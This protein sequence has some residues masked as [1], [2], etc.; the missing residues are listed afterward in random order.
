MEAGPADHSALENSA[1]LRLRF[2][3]QATM[4]GLFSPW[5]VESIHSGS[6]VCEA[7]TSLIEPTPQPKW[8]TL[9]DTYFSHKRP[10]VG[11]CY[12]LDKGRK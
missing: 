12:Y 9:K 6:R 11:N 8:Q 3:A 2:Q 10:E 7:S 1:S 4:P 5:I